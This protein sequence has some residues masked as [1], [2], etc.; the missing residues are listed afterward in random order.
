[1][2]AYQFDDRNIQW[3]QLGEFKHF[4]YAILDIDLENTIADVLFK[5]EAHQPIVLHRHMA[6]NKMLVI[7]GEH[8][9]YEPNGD[10]KEIRPVGR[11]T[12]S[13]ASPDP[14]RECGGDEGAVVFFSIRCKRKEDVLYELLDDQENLIGT[15][16]MADLIGLY[17]QNM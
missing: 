6:L 11:Y 7:Q 12:S 2:N 9:L 4:V 3:H 8:W 5:F 13:P 14:H 10:L 17:E 1:M 15:I 16:T